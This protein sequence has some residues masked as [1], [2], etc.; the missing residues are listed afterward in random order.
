RDVPLAVEVDDVGVRGD[1]AEHAG[2]RAAPGRARIA[3]AD[4]E[5]ELLPG[6]PGAAAQERER[7]QA[8]V[9]HDVP[10]NDPRPGEPAPVEP[11]AVAP[12]SRE[13]P[14]DADR[15]TGRDRSGDDLL[16]VVLTDVEEPQAPQDDPPQDEP[17][18]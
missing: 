9:A 10:G 12:E 18:R 15:E 5:L 7:D 4:R 14:R 6:A 17:E 3:A 13:G 2:E 8:E 1:R 16:R 11:V